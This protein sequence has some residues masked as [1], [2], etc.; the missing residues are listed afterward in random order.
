MFIRFF[1]VFIFLFFLSSTRL[2]AQ[3]N[4]VEFG[5][6]R[7][8]YN[9]FKWSFY[10]SP[11]F[12]VHYYQN[13]LEIAKFVTQVAEQDLS[14]LE[15]FIEFSV[16]RRINI[17]VYNHFNDYKQSNIG[18]G[19]E[20]PNAGG[21]TRLVNNKMVV[22][23]N[24]D[25]NHLRRQIREGIARV[26]V[27]T[28]LFGDDIGEFAQNQALLDLPKW[29]TDGYISYAAEAWNTELDNQLKSAMLGY[30]YKNFYQFA[31]EQ[32]KLAGH[33]FWYYI[34]EKYKRESV[35]YILYLSRLYKNVNK[36]TLSIC[37]KKLKTILKDFMQFNQNKYLQDVRARKDIPS[38]KLTLLKEI[39]K[40]DFFRFQPNPN[41]KNNTYVFVQYN[42]GV[43]KVIYTENF[44]R[45]FVL[46]RSGIQNLE[47]RPNPN[48]PLLAWDPKGTQIAIIVWQKGKLILHIYNTLTKKKT[49]TQQTLPFEQIN[50]VQF[51]LDA[52]TLILSGVRGGQSDIYIYKIAEHKTDQITNDIYDDLDASF[53]TFPNKTGIL[54]SSNRPGPVSVDG[55]TALPRNRFNVFLIDNWNRTEFKQISQLSNIP[56]GNARY[57]TQFNVNHFTFISD[58]SGIGNRWA[59]FFNTKAAGLDTVYQVGEDLLRNPSSRELDSALLIWNKQMPDS[60]FTFRVTEDTAYTFPISNYQSSVLESRIAGDKGQVSEVNKQGTFKFIYKLKVD[61]NLLKKRNINARPTEYVKRLFRLSKTAGAERKERTDLT[62][63]IS[64]GK[65]EDLYFESE[66]ENELSAVS[67]STNGNSVFSQPQEDILSRMRVFKYQKKYFVDNLTTSFI[68]NN[69]LLINRFQPY[70]GATG[71]VQ[72][73]NNNSLN[74]MTRVGAMEF[75]EDYKFSG[76]FRMNYGFDDKEVFMRYDNLRRR[77]DW[78]A[79]YYRSTRNTN[80]TN[81]SD[82]LDARQL[83]NIYQGNVSYP[84]NEVQSIRAIFGVR[85]DRYIIRTDDINFQSLTLPDLDEHFLMLRAEFVHDNTIAPASN[86]WNGLRGKGWFELY[87]RL[88]GSYTGGTNGRS[89]KGKLTFN[90]GFDVRHYMPLYRNIIWA[91]RTAGDFSWG[92]NKFIYYLG[93]TDGWLMLGNN[94]VVRDG[95]EKERYFNTSNRPALDETYVY[96]S[97]AVNMRGFTQNAANGNNAF[98]IN[99]EI[100]VPVFST[101]LNRPVNNSFLRNFQI[102]QF[103]DLGTA[104][105]GKYNNL[106]RPEIT[107][108]LPENPLTVVIKAP[109][110]GPFLGSYGFGARTTL[111]GYFI[112]FDAG[113]QMN[114][115]F[116]N[117][118]IMHVSLGFDF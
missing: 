101:F 29:M 34:D 64:L 25:H 51:M 112:R 59:G 39:E 21:V 27:E 68:S 48:Y 53:V 99:S 89:T 12:N 94:R 60:V 88:G 107:Y 106:A 66:F 36:A 1:G 32:P 76:G 30:K 75:M 109:G 49:V 4:M 50:D 67:D 56:F 16:Q 105:N 114:G 87:N 61:E 111:L 98:V 33:A 28:L 100:R 77:L 44:F 90:I 45:E 108:S 57:P 58:E 24:G 103:V 23:F 78:G 118:P 70:S 82:F 20:W 11:N 93:G 102:I 38:G 17:V 46:W 8:Q 115:F 10:Q 72:L 52:N 13:G 79:T 69:A 6:N 85:S 31:F 14:G 7:V 35:T 113:W 84:F 65:K 81:G 37:R 40:K 22:Y 54:F 43:S 80:L 41:P 110:I 2:F 63:S 62:D 5:K 83:T 18:L 86:I 74:A 104:W 73:G 96:E 95:V 71:P 55:D 97:L 92:N 15:D 26:L 47:D 116:K 117:K 19:L 42:K 91:V 3:V 9:R